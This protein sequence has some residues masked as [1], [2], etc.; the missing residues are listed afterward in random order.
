MP[1]G[2]HAAVGEWLPLLGPLVAGLWRWLDLLLS[3]HLP[4]RENGKL[5]GFSA[6]SY[7][8]SVLPYLINSALKIEE[9]QFSPWTKTNPHAW[10]PPVSMSLVQHRSP[11]QCFHVLVCCICHLFPAVWKHCDTGSYPAG[12]V[13]HRGLF[14]VLGSIAELQASCLSVWMVLF[15]TVL[16]N[17]RF[18]W[19]QRAGGTGWEICLGEEVWG[20]QE[21]PCVK[22]VHH[23]L[24]SV[25]T[26]P[27][28]CRKEHGGF[29][30][31]VQYMHVWQ[32]AQVCMMLSNAPKEWLEI[33][34]ARQPMANP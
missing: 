25:C 5:Q 16:Q 27:S 15:E 13:W 18:V 31:I 4:Y 28:T 8:T 11:P 9:D 22:F 7:H 30:S 33:P 32:W 1:P 20:I 29:E 14:A 12:P 34:P 6:T 2:S 19:T 23:P 21:E 3:W 26:M 24:G 10:L 17:N